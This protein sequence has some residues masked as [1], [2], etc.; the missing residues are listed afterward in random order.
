MTSSVRVDESELTAFKNDQQVDPILKKLLTLP[1][2]ELKRKNFRTSP[3]GIL[4]KV[5]DEKQRSVVP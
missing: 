4:V 2:V 1:K 5:E 3:K